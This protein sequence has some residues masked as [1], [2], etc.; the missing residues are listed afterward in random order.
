MPLSLRRAVQRQLMN[1]KS[2]ALAN[3]IAEMGIRYAID[4]LKPG[5]TE[6]EV[7]A[8]IEYKIRA[9]GPG[10]KGARLMRAFA[11]VGAGPVGSTKGTLLIPSTTYVLQQGD[12]VMIELARMW[13]DISLI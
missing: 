9:S 12:F 10:Y 5:M 13:M 6:A 1:L 7:G 8:M 2:C 4:N 3:E 11:E